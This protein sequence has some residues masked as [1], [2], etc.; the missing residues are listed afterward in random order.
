MPISADPRM[1][2]HRLSSLYCSFRN[3]LYFK[4]DLLTIPK[5][6]KLIWICHS[7]GGIVVKTASTALL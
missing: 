3:S 1:R 5:H 7:L 2:D 6:H 4:S